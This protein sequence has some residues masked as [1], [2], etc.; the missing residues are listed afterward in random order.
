MA[1]HFSRARATKLRVNVWFANYK[2]DFATGWHWQN[3]GW[4]SIEHRTMTQFFRQPENQGKT[5]IGWKTYTSSCMI[6]IDGTRDKE[7]SDEQISKVEDARL[8]EGKIV[9][10]RAA[11]PCQLGDPRCMQRERLAP[12][13]V[14]YGIWDSTKCAQRDI[15]R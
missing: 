9:S 4:V 10:K 2:S 13:F 7:D 12:V 1:D 3:V 11:R 5:Y 15:F 14:N 6:N 8:K